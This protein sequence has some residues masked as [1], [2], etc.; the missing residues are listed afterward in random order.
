MGI[1]R[2][3]V[4]HLI[5]SNGITASHKEEEV[6]ERLIQVMGIL[7]SGLSDTKYHPWTN[8]QTTIAHYTYHYQIFKINIV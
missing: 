3:W 5:I 6:L 2:R 8:I 1:R 4:A 7:Q